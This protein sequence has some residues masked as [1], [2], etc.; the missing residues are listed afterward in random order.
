MD[1]LNQKRDKHLIEEYEK[2]EQEYFSQIIDEMIENDSLDMLIAQR[3]KKIDKEFDFEESPEFKRLEEIYYKRYESKF[4]NSN[5]FDKF[6]EIDYPDESK[7]KIMQKNHEDEFYEEVIEFEKD[8]EIYDQ[9]FDDY[10]EY[11]EP[12]IDDY[13]FDEYEKME[14]HYSQLYEQMIGEAFE[15]YSEESENLENLIK[16]HLK[17][18]TEFLDNLLVDTIVEDHLFEKAIDELIFDEIGMDY[19]EDYF[20]HGYGD[21]CYP[22][23]ESIIDPFDSFGE[24][25]YPEGNEDEMNKFYES[26]NFYDEECEMDFERPYDDYYDVPEPEEVILEPPEE[27]IIEYKDIEEVRNNYLIENQEKIE[28]I[29]KDYFTKDDTLDK[30]IKEKLK[31]KKFNY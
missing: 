13:G 1:D 3:L 24:I 8:L 7:L 5:S 25:D 17:E 26:I 21:E 10:Y 19:P 27:E 18:E 23:D 30:I 22:A 16:I 14:N 4:I 15:E 12:K 9:Q 20:I 29:F 28:N 31:E 6:D 11:S 2:Y